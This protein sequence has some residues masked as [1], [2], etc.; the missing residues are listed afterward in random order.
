MK[1]LTMMFAMAMAQ[2]TFAGPAVFG[3]AT[4]AVIMGSAAAQ[5]NPAPTKEILRVGVDPNLKPFVYQTPHDKI[6]GFDVEIAEEACRRLN[7]ECVFVSTPWDGLIPSLKSKKIDAIITAMSITEAREEVVDFTRP[8]YKSPDQLM[9]KKGTQYL[10]PGDK[11]GVL[12]GSTAE[13]Y[14][15]ANF[16][17]LGISITTYQNQ[18]E[19][20][21]DLKAGRV[22]AVLGPRIELHYGLIEGYPD[23][24][25]YEF[26]GPNYDDPFYYGPGIGM[27]VREGD[28]LR[29]Q[30]NHVIND[31]LADGSWQAINDRYFDKSVNIRP[32]KQ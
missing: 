21:L 24:K 15:Q 8:Y 16:L 19:A 14:A 6:V 22:Q 29:D 27:A 20:F 1:V 3:G 11:V 7:R 25:N 4:A 10:K 5:N 18:N 13:A 12:R 30:L 17:V 31:M 23:G 9:V 28:K 32:P 2:L 26:I